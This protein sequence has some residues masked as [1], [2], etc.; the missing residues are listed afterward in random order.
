ML[1]NLYGDRGLVFQ[2][3]ATGFTEAHIQDKI[4]FD[5]VEAS[6]VGSKFKEA[7][8]KAYNAKFLDDADMVIRFAEPIAAQP[9]PDEQN[10]GAEEQTQPPEEN[11][12]GGEEQNPEPPK[13]QKP[14]ENPE[15]QKP[16]ENPE[17]Q[18]PEEKPEEQKP[19]E[20][21]GGE[22]QK[23]EDGKDG[24]KK[25]NEAETTATGPDLKKKIL[26]TV[27]RCLYQED[28]S[29]IEISDLQGY[30]DGYNISF[31]KVSLK[32]KDAA[33]TT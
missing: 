23:P 6:K 33:P 14:E 13:E 4:K 19:E 20:N 17:E 21:A 16:E 3:L 30:M 32:E 31:I 7:V 12:G 24:K 22:E 15:E 10:G 9:A 18:K 5:V 29:K 11:A 25:V 26:D 28:E 27:K 8:K 2:A 1:V